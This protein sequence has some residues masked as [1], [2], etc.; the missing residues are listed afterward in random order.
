MSVRRFTDE[1]PQHFSC[2]RSTAW[3][4]YVSED[5]HPLFILVILLFQRKPR[6]FGHCIQRV[7][8]LLQ[9]HAQGLRFNL[10][11]GIIESC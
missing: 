10:L 8:R 4:N 1:A 11:R 2:Q 3:H 7:E 5:A 6:S 9:E